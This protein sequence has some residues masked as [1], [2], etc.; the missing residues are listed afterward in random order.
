VAGGKVGW[1]AATLA[2]FLLASGMERT[3]AQ[4]APQSHTEAVAVAALDEQLRAYGVW[5]ARLFAAYQPAMD[6][7]KE[8]AQLLSNAG[9]VDQAWQQRLE[10]LLE[11]YHGLA[12]QIDAQLASFDTPDFPA[13]RLPVDLRT[14]AL[15]REA[16]RLV[17]DVGAYSDSLHDFSEAVRRNDPQAR[18]RAQQATLENARALIEAQLL[19][20]RARLVITPRGSSA[21]EA[22]SLRIEFFQAGL[23]LMQAALGRQ[24][25]LLA[26]AFNERADRV[27]QFTRDGRAKL[28]TEI[29]NIEAMQVR[30]D[31]ARRPTESAMARRIV[32]AMHRYREGFELYANFEALLRNM[33]ALLR[34]PRAEG[35]LIRLAGQYTALGVRIDRASQD[36][37]EAL[38]QR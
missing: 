20:E 9:P 28:D 6:V 35:D 4:P 7:A 21:W 2:C 14:G 3:V 32:E 17:H 18:A 33:A 23:D 8:L 5:F 29:R 26:I 37:V 30:I 31:A 12:E 11:R 10:A 22:G 36:L 25:P 24:N 1:R 38:A 27:A 34:G 19:S 15:L 13:L 16:R